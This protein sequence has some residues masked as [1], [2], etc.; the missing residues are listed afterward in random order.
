MPNPEIMTELEDAARELRV[1]PASLAAVASIESALRDAAFVDGRAE[2]LIRFEGHYFDRRLTGSRRV[3]ARLAGLASPVAGK[4]PNP[5][6]Q[7]ARWDILTRA[8]AIDRKAAFES[9]SWGLGQVMGAHWAWLG[10]RD[11]DAL[12]AD[13]RSGAAGQLRLMTLYIETA[14]LADALRNHDW[15]RFARGYNGPGYR[16]NRYDAKLAAAYSS[17]APEGASQPGSPATGPLRRGALGQEVR[18]LQLALAALGYSLQADG[19]FGPLTEAAILRFQ[20]DRGLVVDGIVGPATRKALD[21]PSSLWSFLAALRRILQR[22][23]R[24]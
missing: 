3:Q 14:G 11:V 8:A 10:Y 22:I 18:A 12:V 16:A 9:T 13:A 7:A 20:A 6:S 21:E 5:A 23:A 19:V 17:F 15:A 1:E 2:P 24:H 4:V